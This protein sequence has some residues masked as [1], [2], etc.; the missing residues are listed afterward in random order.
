MELN[1]YIK[2]TVALHSL[3]T[4]ATRWSRRLYFYLCGVVSAHKYWDW[5]KISTNSSPHPSTSAIIV[6]QVSFVAACS[7]FKSTNLFN[8][9]F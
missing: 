5:N 8:S 2:Y 1:Y 3:D 6:I 7:N 4:A 9:S